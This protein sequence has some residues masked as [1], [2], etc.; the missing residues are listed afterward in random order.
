MLKKH[1]L[2]LARNPG[3]ETHVFIRVVA[4]ESFTELLGERVDDRVHVT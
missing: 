1:Y 2:S 3:L 4:D